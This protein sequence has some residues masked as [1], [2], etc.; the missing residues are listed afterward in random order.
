MRTIE[1]DRWILVRNIQ[2]ALVA[3]YFD[4]IEELIDWIID[5]EELNAPDRDEIAS[6]LEELPL[7]TLV[8][9]PCL[10]GT[11]IARCVTHIPILQPQEV[12]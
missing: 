11:S 7:G 9:F 2:S 6:C 3:D 4:E 8:D 5:S 1:H 10:H 12:S